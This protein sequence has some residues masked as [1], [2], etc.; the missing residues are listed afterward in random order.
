MEIQN[1]KL[2]GIPILLKLGESCGETGDRFP[3]NEE[4]EKEYIYDPHTQ[5]TIQ[6]IECKG[7]TFIW[8]STGKGDQQE[9]RRVD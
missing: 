4:I 2:S 7:P 3:S 5:R 6:P 1:E 9:R 8:V